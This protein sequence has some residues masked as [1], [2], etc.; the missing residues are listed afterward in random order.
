[1][2]N[3]LSILSLFLFTNAS[4]QLISD[5]KKFADQLN[6][7]EVFTFKHKEDASATQKIEYLGIIKAKNKV[8]YKV[9][10]SHKNLGSKGINDLIFV[11]EEGKV[12]QYRLELKQDMPIRILKN[13]LVF[14]R[15]ENDLNLSMEIEE[16]QNLFCTPFECFPLIE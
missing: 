11:A 15:E 1:M 14:R 5:Y 7:K 10:T 2:K 13:K 8:N 6:K 12:F 16:L 4:A 3:L 9:L